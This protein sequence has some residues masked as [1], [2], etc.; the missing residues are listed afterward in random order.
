MKRPVLT[1]A[2]VMSTLGV[3][4]ALGGT[5]YAVA[6][7]SI[8]TPQL[9]NNAV[10]SGKVRNGSLTAKDLA[11]NA[12]RAGPRGPRGQIGPAGP[13]GP[14]GPVGDAEAWKPLPYINGWTD[15]GNIWELGSYRKDQLGVVH[16][17]GLVRQSTTGP[18]PA[19]ITVLPPGYRP[20]HGRL[21]VVHTG[22]SSAGAAVPGEREGRVQVLSDGQVVWVQGATDPVS[23]YTSLEGI[24]FD[25][26]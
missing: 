25:T 2:N 8:G 6:R 15:Y 12:L 23:N 10:T 18:V 13:T 21:F 22:E 16:L 26:D 5:S 3:F 1:Y 17:R 9:K 11:A 4:I 20:A 7:N 24:S 14:A 19:A